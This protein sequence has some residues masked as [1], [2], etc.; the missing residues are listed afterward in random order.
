MTRDTLFFNLRACIPIC[1]ASVKWETTRLS[2]IVILPHGLI[3]RC[4]RA[5]F[6][7]MPI[8]RSLDFYSAP[9]VPASST[10]NFARGMW[11]RLIRSHCT[12]I[13][14]ALKYPP[15]NVQ[16]LC[17]PS[18][19][20]AK[21]HVSSHHILNQLRV[22]II[23]EFLWRVAVT[24]ALLDWTAYELFGILISN[25]YHLIGEQWMDWWI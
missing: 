3:S 23:Y 15:S 5:V 22:L 24:N 17:F 7:A 9:P 2:K 14:S 25:K 6:F 8:I 1:F 18:S 12:K 21:N 19:T 10:W 20:S 16:I 4:I 11:L 13:I